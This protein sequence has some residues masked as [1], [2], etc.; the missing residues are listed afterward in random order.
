MKATIQWILAV[1]VL[2]ALLVWGPRAYAAKPSRA[3]GAVMMTNIVCNELSLRA[4]IEATTE[5]ETEAENMIN[6]VIS[7]GGCVTGPYLVK[8]IAPA[9]TWED[10]EGDIFQVWEIQPANNPPPAFPTFTWEHID[11]PT[12]PSNLR[13]QP[14]PFRFGQPRSQS[15]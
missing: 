8:I 4:I 14:A 12:Y 13:Q 1:A 11:G 15:I 7:R 2:S 9:Y 5:G 10:W 3:A 6:W